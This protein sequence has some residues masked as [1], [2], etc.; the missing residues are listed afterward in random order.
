MFGLIAG[1]LIPSKVFYLA[2]FS[3]EDTA[4]EWEEARD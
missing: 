2:S 4:A 1:R 3:L